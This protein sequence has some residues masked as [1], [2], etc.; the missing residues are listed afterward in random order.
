[1]K[2]ID[3]LGWAA[4]VSFR[5]CGLHLGV[6]VNDPG[7]MDQV[8]ERL[9]PGW[10]PA[11]SPYV[12]MLFSLLGGGGGP[13][14]NVR[15]FNLAYF[16]A[17]RLA[18]TTDLAEAL[19]ALEQGMDFYVSSQAR[20]RVFVRAGVV[21]FGRKAILI[22]GQRNSG[23]T[24]LVAELVRQ[25]A[26]YYSD[27]HAVLDA[28]GRVHPYARPLSVYSP[29]GVR[30]RMAITDL[31]GVAGVKPLPVG[32]VVESEYR[33]G[34][35]WRAQ[36]LSPGNGVLALLANTVSARREPQTTLA[37]LQQVLSGARFLRSVRGEARETAS[38]ILRELNADESLSRTSNKLAE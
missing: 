29:M 10:K 21:A 16:D 24:T 2:K 37:T 14:A 31:G 38:A 7:L 33:A 6:R 35:K 22:P 9:P 25:G 36:E 23:K 27:E 18:R 13:R 4:G 8:V 12:E 20:R 5:V 34:R 17:T 15:R 32:L 26:T 30:G 19:E 11:E 28:Q 1:M 3:R